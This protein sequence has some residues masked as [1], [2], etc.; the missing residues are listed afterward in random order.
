MLD[1]AARGYRHGAFSYDLS[2]GVEAP[3]LPVP[4]V[5]DPDHDV[6]DG[7]GLPDFEYVR[8][9]REFI[10]GAFAAAERKCQ[11]STKLTK[12]RRNA[13]GAEID[14]IDAA[15]IDQ[16]RAAH[17]AKECCDCEG[18]CA[19][20]PDC[21]CRKRNEALRGS[22]SAHRPMFEC[23]PGCACRDAECALR[24]TQAPHA[25]LLRCRRY[26][27]KGWGVQTM[28]RIAKG[29]Y[30]GDYA[31]DV[32][33][34]EK[35][36]TAAETAEL[37]ARTGAESYMLTLGERRSEWRRFSVDG[38]TRGNFSKMINH[39]CD[40]NLAVRLVREA[41]AW[42]L[43]WRVCLFAKRDIEVGEELTWSYTN[44]RAGRSKST[45]CYCGSQKCRGAL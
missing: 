16:D 29:A 41:G 5:V 37:V 42:G 28:E 13:I 8:R 45:K 25:L 10:K 17:A 1:A 14:E 22:S 33:L 21:P 43:P 6:L 2:G 36:R 11:K 7:R 27:Y 23:G 40:P 4:V 39:S 20:N 31:G 24:A 32:H 44:G 19:A 9:A 15:R 18:D 12:N 30:V 3:G 38:A 26:P 34:G 35:T